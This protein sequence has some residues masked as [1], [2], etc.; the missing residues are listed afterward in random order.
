MTKGRY[1]A[2]ALLLMG[3][4]ICGSL[5]CLYAQGVQ[6]TLPN[7]E[8]ITEEIT[9]DEND[10]TFSIGYK[11]AGDYLEV[12][13]VMTPQEYNRM[14]MQ[15]SLQSFYRDKYAEEI[16]AQG[17]DKFDFTNM[18][19]DLGPAE[20]IFGPGGVQ[21]RTSG[22]A[23]VK[24]GYNRNKVDNPSL[25]VQNRSTGG[26]D[27]DEQI[28]LNIRASVGDKV[29]MNLNYNTEA[30]FDIDAKTIKLRYEGKEDE[31]IRLLE[32]GNI[33]FPT[34]SSL[35]Q[36]A[37]S[38]F[39]IRSDLQFGKLKLQM[40]LSQKESSSATVNSQ[41]GQQI[42][43]F[44]I[45][46]SSYDENRHFFLAHFFR[47]NYDASMAMLP[48]IVSG[49]QITRIEVW[50]T[51][52]K[53]NYDNPRNIVAF[54]D[55]GETDHISNSIWNAQGGP[56]PANAANDLYN[57]IVNDYPNARDI[58]QVAVTLGSF[59]DGSSDYE[60]I[61]NA[62]KLGTSDYTLNSE[63]G[64][65][66]LKNA[67]SSDEVLAVAFEYTYGG[68][69]YQVG[70]FSSDKTDAKE[71]LY[72]KLLKSN[73]N[74]PGSG[75]WDLM[76]KNIYSITRGNIQ[77]AQFKLG[78]YYSSDSTG[79]RLTYIPESSLK[80]TPLIQLLNL[81]RLDDK[82]NPHPNGKF[83]FIE[84]Y[85]VQASNGRIIFPVVE[86]F[87]SHL[88]KV[89][90]NDAIA[91]K[92]VFQEL[93]DS[94]RV[95][96]K[97][98]ADK[99]KFMLMGQYSGTSS[100]VIQL[101]SYNIPRGSVIVTAG[102]V[103]LVEN[104]D[105]TVDYSMGTVTIINQSIIDAG[106]SVNVQLE[107]NT[108]FSM[109]R[110]TMA[111]LNWMY[112]FGPNLQLGGT[113]M[114]L[115]EKPLTS[116]VTM[117][118]EPLVNTMYGLNVSWRR[119]SQALTNII[120]KIPFVHATQPSSINFKAE[121][122]AL[123]SSVSDKV[124]GQASYIDDFE[125]AETGISISQPSAWT[126]S[127]VPKGMKGYG[128]SGQVE[129]GY[130]R[131]LLNWFTI[132]PLFTRRNSPLTPAHIKTDLDQLSNH[133]VRE[134]YER[135]LY[136]NK[137]STSSESTTLQIL[138]LAYYPNE[139]GP[140][141]LN[142]DLDADGHLSN[143]QDNWA[144][145]MRRLTT[146]DFEAAN[147]E[148]IEFW[149]LD[150]F[151]YNPNATGGDLY[152]NL[153][154]VSEDVLLDGKKFFENG[155]PVDDDTTKW[156]STVWGKVPTGKSLVYA[157]DNNAADS[158]DR[159]DVGL[160]G[161]T[162]Q[163]ERSWPAYAAYLNEIQGKVKPDVYKGIYDDPAA[164]SYHYYR[165]SDYDDAH[166]SVL[167]RYRKFNGT[168][169]NS[170]NSAESGSRY[171]QSARTTPDVEDAN[172][173]YT[174]D[175]YEK[176]FQYRISLRP[177]DLEIG[178]NYITDKR[179]VKVKLRNGNTETVNWYCFRIPITEYEKAE[180]GIRD[181]SS[182]RFMRMYLT[183]F[184]EEVHVRFGSLELMTS[185]WRN[186]EQPIYSATNRTP[187]I[188]GK[189]SAASVNIEENGDRAPVNYVVPPGVTRILDPNQVQLVQDNEQAM[190]LKV[191]GLGAG[192]ARGIY[193]KS[194]LD[195]RKYQRIQ[196]FSHAEAVIPDDGSLQNGD[197]SVFIRLGSDYSGN[198]YEYEIPLD[199]TPPGHYSGTNENDRRM[200]WPE[201][202][203]LDIDFNVL[204][205]VKNNRN[206]QKN[207]GAISASAIYS[208]YDPNNPENR[209]TVV[210]N[211]SIGNVRAIMI[212]VRNNSMSAKN[213]EVWVN[214]LR[215]VGYESKGGMAAL[216][217]L[218]IKLS[219]LASVDMSGQMST[220]GYGGLEQSI[221]DRKTDDYYKYS[222]TTSTNVGRF[223][224][225][226]SRISVPVY[227]SYTKEK[228]SPKYSPYDTDLLLDDVIE[229]YPEG[230]ARDSIQSI[231]Q[232]LKESHNFSISNAKVNISSENPMPY[233]PANFS[234]SYSESSSDRSNSTIDYEH[235]ENWRASLDYSYSP[236]LNG[237]SPFENIPFESQ[238]FSIV[239]D[240]RISFLPQ[241]ISFNT[242]LQRNYHELQERDLEGYEGIPV[243]FSQQFYWN[244]D[245][246]LSW[247]PLQLLRLSFTARTRAEIEEPYTVVNKDLY[248][249]QY[250]LWKDSVKMSLMNMGRPLDYSQ[251]FNASYN[252]P[253]NK[254]PA[255][256]WMTADAGFN[257]NYSWNRGTTYANGTNYGNIIANK[258]SV[259]L[260]GRFNMLNLYN[261]VTYLHRINTRY[262]S[263]RN[264]SSIYSSS[265][266]RV[267]QQEMTLLPGKRYVVKHILGT[268]NP[269]LTATTKDGNTV[270]IKFRKLGPDSVAIKVKDTLNVVIKMM[271]DPDKST[272]R[273]K[274]SLQEGVD[275]GV[276]TL[277]MVR[278]VSVSYRN[279]YSMSLPGFMPNS[280]V[281]G[282]NSTS[283]LLA[284]G[285]DFAFGL[286]DDDYLYKAIDNG[287]LLSG[288]DIAHTA[289]SNMTE[290][291]QVKMTIEP[292]RDIKIDANASWN[293]SGNNRIQYM[294]AGMPSSRG[295]S[296][297]MTTI[298]IGSAFERH[299]SKN[300]YRSR[301]FDRFTSSL[302]TFHD[303]IES[304]YAGAYY[305]QRSTLA[306]QTYDPANGGVDMY[307]SDVLI[308]AF[309][310]AYTG[311][312][313]NKASIDLFP[314]ALSM[315]PN[316]SFTYS[317]LSKLPFFKK[318]FKSFNLTH[319][320][321]SVYSVGNFNTFN[322]YMEYLNGRGFIEDVT[323]GNPIPSTMFNISSVSINESFSPLCGVNM[324]FLN[325]VSARLEYRKTRVLTLSTT[326]VQVVETTSDDITAGTSY[327]INAIKLFGAQPGSG[328][329]KVSNDLNMNLDFSLRNQNALCRNLREETTQATSGN[330][331]VKLSFS[332]DYTY[333]R[334]L[335]LNFYYDFQS[336]FPLVSTS[337]YPT[338]THDAG[339][340]L[341]FTL[342]R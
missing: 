14:M 163:E 32:A 39:G 241:S 334:M 234:F 52:K 94:T 173:D 316:W 2:A 202:N 172:G 86:P 182:I 201:R 18:K 279:D 60:K 128:K 240:T 166:L 221:M 226:N 170:P 125:A 230:H 168:E 6:R 193:K 197:I 100:N 123:Q 13:T 130:N 113:F 310:A 98:I 220:A 199:L 121:M 213:A 252:I 243:S 282:Q 237:W 210:G 80:N 244:R 12:P 189:F 68:N 341:K 67:L 211:P 93:Y 44:E 267:F 132:D 318:Y 285:L 246:S 336:N 315:L 184:S 304:E 198:Y 218:G 228:T 174:M 286:T 64:Y 260:N 51:N 222:I 140:Y 24:F 251:S 66:S 153:G 253:L 117:G 8:N 34:N 186:Y 111:G 96:A 124:Q 292:F 225:E 320:Y 136:P 165:G 87:G 322:S 38:L 206:V 181:F 76:M 338:S 330:R 83:D 175:E 10:E 178:R 280:K 317:G 235:D 342:T 89:I 233:D 274:F 293:K 116:K 328:R 196:M 308:P 134:V 133:Y 180:G 270:K 47:D 262:S 22:S 232:D 69:S 9:Y 143:P 73:S 45:D 157:F 82:N 265:N 21:V 190:S 335:T 259:S 164:D 266:T 59:L 122:A 57:R 11:L 139:R 101:G 88:R 249:D 273:K 144:G 339:F 333:S 102:G 290:D 299:S 302:A 205:H 95:I 319:A 323:S 187:S 192:E 115:N 150:P 16:K 268:M 126:L 183:G 41:G 36:G 176:F 185:Q 217:S 97:R 4:C 327:K 104:S 242:G 321:K 106:T 223:L 20:K 159:Q 108:E 48:S 305:P 109:Q 131:A 127:A 90:D 105:Y 171:D 156:A 135:E 72:V 324:T 283:G 214:E 62:R 99:D 188:S 200:V 54:T 1:L 207:L 191:T 269:K 276:R 236:G 70:E 149:M 264:N 120:D 15:R 263:N 337:A 40:V 146:T 31:I 138:N 272:R 43:D 46:A 56:A 212:G 256:D 169:G 300:N 275:I 42:T 284:P 255:F 55:L 309:L 25:S 92:Y 155:L 160:N 145:I 3:S 248:P 303:R 112:D 50:V 311:R 81:D 158:R 148:Y 114:H 278:N 37:S 142:P 49:V 238:W 277:M 325:D 177:S 288:E 53:S 195:L 307:S 250:Q 61:S 30:T 247:S 75:T 294:Y 5:D 65:I 7:P 257:S 329:N 227:Y 74:S 162:S 107:S 229:S 289:T 63:L 261:K 301:S 141:N 297:S 154:E 110:K 27:F 33:S 71:T 35:I 152:L 326:A 314:N 281:L 340:T 312:D 151:I 203:M 295:G 119:E 291:L 332:A 306:G 77:S 167:D 78:I 28:N 79:S 313:A 208:E 91:D 231:S 204:T 29:N 84:N 258:R 129:S 58:D 239:R 118:D 298:S 103:T 179:E 17:D 219:D 215:L 194:S 287:W 296:F 23:A 331:A 147:I 209:I 19:F 224:P 254:I 161:L 137:E 271:Q 245:L 85:T 216:S 26:F